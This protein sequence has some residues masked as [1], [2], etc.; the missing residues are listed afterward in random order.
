MLCPF[1]RMLGHMWHIFAFAYVR[2]WNM[3]LV[4]YFN[5]KDATAYVICWFTCLLLLPLLYYHTLLKVCI[6][7]IVDVHT[8]TLRLVSYPSL[9]KCFLSANSHFVAF[10]TLARVRLFTASNGWGVGGPSEPSPS[11]TAPDGLRASRRKKTSELRSTRGSRWYPI[12]RSQ[13]NRWP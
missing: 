7:L 11:R 5:N 6:Q 9:A 13:V 1:S 3:H 10:L 8:I 4:P 2:V 12:L